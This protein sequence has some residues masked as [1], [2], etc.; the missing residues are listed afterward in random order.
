VSVLRKV[1]GTLVK[2]FVSAKEEQ[3]G[4]MIIQFVTVFLLLIGTKITQN[5]NVFLRV[6]LTVMANVFVLPN[7]IGIL[8]KL[9][10]NVFQRVFGMIM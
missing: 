8:A 10:V 9:I 4:I 6:L 2:L 3:F 1:N 7:K 5:A